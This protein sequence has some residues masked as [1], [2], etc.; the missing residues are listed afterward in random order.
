MILYYETWR[1]RQIINIC[2]VL[3]SKH[4]VDVFCES[5]ASLVSPL[6]L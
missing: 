4:I 1:R 2:D 3:E 6:R 5:D